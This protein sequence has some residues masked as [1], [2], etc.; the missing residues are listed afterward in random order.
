MMNVVS[1]CASCACR[2]SSVLNIV[3]K[4]PLYEQLKLMYS[5][6]PLYLSVQHLIKS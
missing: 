6:A 2:A 1:Q 4:Q 5:S 3:K